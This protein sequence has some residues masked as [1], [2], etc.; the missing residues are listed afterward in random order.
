[1]IVLFWILSPILVLCSRSILWQAV[2]VLFPIAAYSAA[3]VFALSSASGLAQ[4]WFQ[5]SF[6]RSVS[7]AGPFI[8]LFATIAVAAPVYAWI[9]S[10]DFT[11]GE[12]QQPGAI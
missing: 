10:R 6:S 7:I 4:P 1:M 12:A 8:A 2:G 5:F 3:F 9:S 11:A